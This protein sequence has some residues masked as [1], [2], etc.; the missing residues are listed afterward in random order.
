MEANQII[1]FIVIAII[2][3]T[4]AYLVGYFALRKF[5]PKRLA[6]TESSKAEEE[7]ITYE[8]VDARIYDNDRRRIYNKV[9]DSKLVQAIIE[10]KDRGL[11]LGRQWNYNGKMVYALV[12]YQDKDHISQYRPIEVYMTDVADCPPFD[13][14]DAINQPEVA[15]TDDVSVE[16]NFVQKYGHLLLFCFGIAFIIFMIVSSGVR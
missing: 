4:A 15:L 13:I 2:A 8:P 5:L 7:K 1:Q 10:N 9:L 11:G 3:G 12:K 6:K 16:G 14:Y